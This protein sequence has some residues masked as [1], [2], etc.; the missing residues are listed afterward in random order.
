[1][2]TRVME[3]VLTIIRGTRTHALTHREQKRL[4]IWAYKTAIVLALVT[5]ADERVVPPE[6]YKHLFDAGVPPDNTWIW[7]AGVANQSGDEVRAA[8]EPTRETGLPVICRRGGDCSWLPPVLQH[9]IP[10]IP[11]RLGSLR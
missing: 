1:M 11:D 9:R 3:I 2:E 7:I 10:R 8:T 5:S 4:G 6:H